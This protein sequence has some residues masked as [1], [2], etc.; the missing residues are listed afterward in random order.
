M[1]VSQ[2]TQKIIAILC[3]LL[4]LAV[5]IAIFV[6]NSRS[7]TSVQ[8][9]S[10]SAKTQETK[11]TQKTVDVKLRDIPQTEKIVEAP[12]PSQSFKEIQPT[13][14]EPKQSVKTEKQSSVKKFTFTAQPGDSYTALARDAVRQ[15]A[16]TYGITV[17]PAQVSQAAA[18]LAVNAGSPRLDI[19]QV[20]TIE[21]S[22]IAVR[23]GVPVSSSSQAKEASP[24]SVEK[25]KATRTT[26]DFSF[27]AVSGD[28]YCLLA[29]RAISEY[30]A[31]AK[32]NLLPTQRIAAETTLTAAADFPQINVGQVVNYTAASIKD[33]VS[34][35]Q[36]L[37]EAQLASWLP[38][39]N[40]AEF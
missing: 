4:L 27:T 18:V 29:R 34:A 17:T 19:G 7:E 16:D 14:P 37:S 39:A 1:Q 32:L 9:S 33:A 40:L 13:K 11:K 3:G 22:D 28:S 23:L 6:R 38:Y 2:K 24:K 31:N 25:D 8:T 26:K 30:A 5:V 15:Y 12:K 21:Q 35:S 10:S 20:V 36:M